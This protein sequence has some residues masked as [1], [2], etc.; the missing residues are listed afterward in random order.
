MRKDRTWFDVSLTISPIRNTAGEIASV[1][2]IARDISDRKGAE[3]ELQR[4][5]AELKRSNEE[6]ENFAYV[7]SH[8]LTEP[9]R[10]VSNYCELISMRY[11]QSLDNDGKEYLRYARDGAKRV[12]TL[13]NELL[14]YS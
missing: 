7:A 11:S 6:L 8:D 5:A 10:M 13:V 9:L 12:I 1:A 3:R 14:D 4:T 2:V